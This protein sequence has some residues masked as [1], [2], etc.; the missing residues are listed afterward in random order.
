MT[1]RAP[2]PVPPSGSP[3]AARL[4]SASCAGGLEREESGRG[5]AAHAF[6]RAAFEIALRFQLLLH[7]RR[8]PAHE[9]EAAGH[10]LP[11]THQRQE[12]ARAL[13]AAHPD[14]EAPIGFHDRGLDICDAG[15]ALVAQAP[16]EALRRQPHLRAVRDVHLPVSDDQLGLAGGEFLEGLGVIDEDLR[17]DDGEGPDE[18]DDEELQQRDRRVVDDAADDA[19]Q[20]VVLDL[21]ERGVE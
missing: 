21:V 8:I 12:R 4:R 9:R 5:R 18:D 20:H 17:R 2:E 3:R 11:V 1:V 15:N 16:A 10:Q 13:S 6:G 14:R 7:P 19:A